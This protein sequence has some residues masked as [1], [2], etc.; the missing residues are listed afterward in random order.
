MKQRLTRAVLALV[1]MVV[2]AV[3]GLFVPSLWHAG[4]GRDFGPQA[5]T[6]AILILIAGVGFR[7]A[8]GWHFLDFVF[9]LLAAEFFTLCT[10]AH[11]TGFTGLEL[12]DFFNLV[13]LAFM[14]LFVGL[15]WFV[16]FGVGSLWL[17]L[18]VR[19]ERGG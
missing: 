17:T 12:F 16:G 13:W 1:A 2:C 10:I 6:M 11:F 3:A 15:P 4:M 8:L 5:A 18:S 14:S 19:H 7:Q 9:G